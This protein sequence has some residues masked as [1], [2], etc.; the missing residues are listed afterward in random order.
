MKIFSFWRS[1][2]PNWHENEV[3]SRSTHV[4]QDSHLISLL[5]SS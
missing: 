5:V 2:A 1:L 4:R 3:A